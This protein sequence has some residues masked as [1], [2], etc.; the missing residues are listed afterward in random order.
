VVVPPAPLTPTT[1]APVRHEWGTRVPCP[2]TGRYDH[3]VI[4]LW[5]FLAISL[6]VGAGFAGCNPTPAPTKSSSG[7]PANPGTLPTKVTSV[8]ATLEPYN[9]AFSNQGI[10]AEQ[11]DFTV[12]SVTGNFSCKIDVLRSGRI[13]G[14]TMA[15]MGPPSEGSSS[16][17]ESV[18]V[19]G[20]RGGTFAGKP[21]NAHVTCHP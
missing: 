3:S 6:I 12:S 1:S 9:P 2:L 7:L 18:P 16:L 20:I 8:T 14:S 10:S 5:P 19:E 17:T 4:R 13:V 15:T 21:S 11:V